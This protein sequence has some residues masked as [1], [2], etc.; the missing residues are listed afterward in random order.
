MPYGRRLDADAISE[1]LG[2]YDQ[3]VP[4][5]EICKTYGVS[6]RTLYRWCARRG[7]AR[8]DL[9]K[10]VAESEAENGALRNELETL[11]Q[12]SRRSAVD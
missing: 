6:E 11:R 4:A 9:N 8:P 5:N 7:K 3:G 1:A 12:I 10:R 2:R